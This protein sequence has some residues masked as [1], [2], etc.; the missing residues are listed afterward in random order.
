MPAVIY[1]FNTDYNNN[2]I[3]RSLREQLMIYWKF[4]IESYFSSKVK[5]EVYR[6][7]P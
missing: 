1:I 6:A 3:I 7:M 4:L 2:I 5:I